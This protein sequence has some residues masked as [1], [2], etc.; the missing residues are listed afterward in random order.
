MVIRQDYI[1]MIQNTFKK[2]Q[3]E[4]KDKDLNKKIQNKIVNLMKEIKWPENHNHARNTPRAFGRYKDSKEPPSMRPIVKK[5]E[6][7]TLFLRKIYDGIL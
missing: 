2:M 7:P 1:E 3:V 4:I 6:G 5:K